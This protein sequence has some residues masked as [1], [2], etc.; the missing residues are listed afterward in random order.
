M[1]KL[2][3]QSL[4]VIMHH[5]VSEDSS[6]I[7]VHP[8]I[9]EEQ[10]RSLAEN[11][12]TGISLD[13]A[14]DFL[15][16]GAFLPKKSFLMTFDDGF[17]DNYVHAW[18]IMHKYGHKGVIFAV[19]DRISEAQHNWE[20]R[21]AS[22]QRPHR[23]TLADVWQGRCAKEDLPDVDNAL[24]LDS[25]GHTVRQ[26]QFFTW[27]EARLMEHSGVMSIAAHSV[28][29]EQVFV[30]PVFSGFLR[31]GNRPR[32]FS[33]TA[34]TA[35]WGMPA[36]E[37]APGLAHRA[38]IPSPD[39]VE[40]ITDLVPQEA[41]EAHAFF[42]DPA[43]VERL[44]AVVEKHKDRLGSYESR[45]AQMLRHRA[46]MDSCR[47]VLARELGHRVRSFCWPWGVFC[48]EAREQGLAAGFE[49]FYTT[50]LGMNFSGD[51]LSVSRFKVKNR[52]DSW[53]IN[54]LRVYSRPWLGSLYLKLRL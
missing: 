45:E 51:H 53:L 33:H 18:P 11:G 22:G 47:D 13:Q 21:R 17:L 19:T 2:P 43:A 44:R 37:R 32:P 23:P 25:L 49:V 38:F 14:E 3:R 36:F 29:H 31:P 7:R 34:P 52:T 40:A 8:A 24:R 16:N 50:R 54:R 26:D 35:F 20:E 12:W 30:G 27:D 42:E 46:V 6:N 4:P 1:K 48:E 41:A 10:C 28:R 9:F 39:L 5:S 15:I